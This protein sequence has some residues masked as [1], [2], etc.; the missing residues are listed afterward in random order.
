MTSECMQKLVHTL[1]GLAQN[2]NISNEKESTDGECI[3]CLG[4]SGNGWVME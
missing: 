3:V 4:F 1:N 2:A